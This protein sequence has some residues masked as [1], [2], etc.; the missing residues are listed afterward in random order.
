MHLLDTEWG[1]WFVT[2][3][4]CRE[5][6]NWESTGSYVTSESGVAVNV[7]MLPINYITIWWHHLPLGWV[8]RPSIPVAFDWLSVVAIPKL[9]MLGGKMWS[10][11]LLW[12]TK[13]LT[14]SCHPSAS[15]SVFVSV[16]LEICQSA[17]YISGKL[18]R[19]SELTAPALWLPAPPSKQT[20]ISRLTQAIKDKCGQSSSALIMCF[21]S[22]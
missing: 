13:D 10:V 5:V 2:V 11:E 4:N 17:C 1:W 9:K 7:Y 12:Q 15:S 21:T 16:S 20:V 19:E 3:S 22:F 6:W 8:R 18:Q 14:M